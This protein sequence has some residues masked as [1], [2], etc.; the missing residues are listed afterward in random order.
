MV[1]ATGSS[2]R[3]IEGGAPEAKK[4]TCYT[5]AYIHTQYLLLL[6]ADHYAANHTKNVCLR[7]KQVLLMV[8]TA[9]KIQLCIAHCTGA[10]GTRKRGA[11]ACGLMEIDLAE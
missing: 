11:V 4:S 8:H 1:L 2:A 10:S 6:T 9:Q 3:A 7:R 5:H